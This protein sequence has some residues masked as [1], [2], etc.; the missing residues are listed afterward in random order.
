MFAALERAEMAARERR[1]VASSE[2]ERITTAARA[3][4]AQILAGAD[5][6]IDDAIERLRHTAEAEADAAIEELQREAF[7][8][9]GDQHRSSDDDPVFERAVAMVVAHV[10]GD[11][12]GIPEP[13]ADSGRTSL[14]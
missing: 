13:A 7:D 10:L 14:P 1:L 2:A 9:I 6:R 3:E 5:P 12:D 8:R 11:A 4:V